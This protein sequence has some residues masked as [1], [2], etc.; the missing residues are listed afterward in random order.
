M[1]G[2]KRIGVAFMRGQP[3][4]GDME[5]NWRTFERLAR[6]AAA[7][8]ADL[9]LSP[10]CFL[11]GYAVVHARWSRRQL[12]AAGRRTT[13]E[14]LP[15]LRRLAAELRLTLLLGATMT[16]GAGCYNSALLAGADG[17]L[18][19]IYDKTHLLDHDLRYDPGRR[20]PVF[21]TPFG[22]V[23]IMIC[24]DRRWPETA[25][26]LRVQ[27]ARLILNPTYG[28]HHRANAWWM[29][30]RSY[31]NE[32]YIC[33]A[34]P[35]LSLVTGPESEVCARRSGSKPGVLLT[36]LD[37]GRLPTRMFDA[38]R[39][40]LYRA[41]VRR[42]HPQAEKGTFLI[43]AQH[44]SGRLGREMRNVPFSASPADP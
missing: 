8:D 14:F 26:C 23:G 27:G 19:G 3:A 42:S 39:P 20:L 41:I 38:R 16:R 17:R 31:E 25:R 18:I 32:C 5:A 35:R 1:I 40:D 15:R 37:P 21:E 33:F 2:T 11:D 36:T 28:M 7:R 30:T 22:P 4:A 9:A 34:H 10:E 12:V 6:R 24:A 44:P 13:R 29:R 43:S